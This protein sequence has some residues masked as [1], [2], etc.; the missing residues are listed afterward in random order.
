MNDPYVDE[1]GVLKNKL[2]I[3][4][5]SLLHK[6]ERDLTF[7]R[8][9]ELKRKSVKG[10]FDFKHL[11][12]IHEYIFQDVYDWAGKTRTV[13]IAKGNMFCSTL[14]IDSYQQDV[15]D[16]L[17]KDDFLR[18]MSREQFSKKAAFYFGEINMLHP[19]REGNGR[20]QREFMLEL[21]R[22]AGWEL[23]LSKVSR[24]EM[25]QASKQ[26]AKSSNELFEKMIHEQLKPIELV[27][28]E[29][30]ENILSNSA[31]K[32]VKQMTAKDRFNHYARQVLETDSGI[33]LPDTNKRIAMAMM[34]D[35]FS[36]RDTEY[37]MKNSPQKVSSMSKLLGKAERSNKLLGVASGRGE[38][39]L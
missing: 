25:I 3:K 1:N 6:A 31:E 5:S 16:Q 14:Y 26:S 10:S 29:E 22:D 39:S 35:G 37:S 38:K 36:V 27:K 21:S 28:K 8:I 13:E 32:D 11:Q 24:E 30:I 34:Q 23:D 33:W 12:K 2:G 15:F 9:E 19:F 17:R 7:S 20:T 18:D 4:S